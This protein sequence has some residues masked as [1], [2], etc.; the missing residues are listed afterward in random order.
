MIRSGRNPHE[1]ALLAAA[2]VLGLAG[3]TAFGQVAT[4]TVRALPDPFGHVLY[5]GL[6]VGALVSLV[7]VFLAGYIGPLLE[8][9]GLIGL[10]LLCAGYAVTILGLFGGRGLSFALFMLAFAAANL[11][12]ARQ[13]GRELD[14]MQAVEVLVRGDRS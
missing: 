11:V 6:A 14:E 9:A 8:R 2:F 1:V 12:R 13:I 10:A 4:T 7:G 5:G 3:L